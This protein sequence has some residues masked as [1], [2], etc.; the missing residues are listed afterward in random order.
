MAVNGI[1][2][3]IGEFREVRINM[4]KKILFLFFTF[5]AA[6]TFINCTSNP[7]SSI[8]GYNEYYDTYDGSTLSEAASRGNLSLTKKLVKAGAYIDVIDDA[9]FTPL[10]ETI[11]F[12]FFH[13][14]DGRLKDRFDCAVYLIKA[15]ASVNQ[16]DNF[17]R[18]AIMYV[19]FAQ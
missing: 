6:A 15:G 19:I 12:M 1:A 9:G 14:F 8:P 16:K 17:G 5:I 11:Y 3:A 13:S 7:Y 4:K 10:T 2:V 18:T